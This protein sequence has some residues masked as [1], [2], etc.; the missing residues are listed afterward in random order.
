MRIK[1]K[2]DYQLKRFVENYRNWDWTRVFIENI[3][4][5][6][7]YNSGWNHVVMDFMCIAARL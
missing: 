2:K 7:N 6:A 5:K 1:G 3:R 4:R